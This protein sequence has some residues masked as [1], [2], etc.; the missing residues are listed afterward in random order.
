MKPVRITFIDEA[1]EEWK[2]LNKIVVEERSKGIGNSE[3]QQLL[4]SIKQ[5]ME[6]IKIDPQYGAP[7][8][9]KL[10][11]KE[12]PVDNLWVVDLTGYWRMLYTLRV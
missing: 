7:V 4:K 2:H 8:S 9:K 3:N 12:L 5:R 6:L 11:P 1:A 10:I